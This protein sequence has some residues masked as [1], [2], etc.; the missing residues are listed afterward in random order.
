MKQCLSLHFLCW[1]TNVNQFIVQSVAGVA[2][3]SLRSIFLSQQTIIQIIVERATL[4]NG[5]WLWN[6]VMLYIPTVV[7]INTVSHER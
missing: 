3:L 1:F 5:F 6:Y 7:S 4:V 2:F